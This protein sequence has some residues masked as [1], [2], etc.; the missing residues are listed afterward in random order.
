MPTPASTLSLTAT[1]RDQHS[2]HLPDGSLNPTGYHIDFE[3]ALGAETG[4]VE[5]MLGGD[6]K[7]VYALDGKPSTTT[8]GKA[9]FDQWY[10]DV[11]NVN[12]SQQI[13]FTLNLTAGS[14]PPQYT[15]SN[16]NFFPIDGML[17]GNE[18]FSHNFS[19]TVELHTKFRYNGGEQFSFTGDDDVFVF[20]NG[21]LAIDLGGV[22]GAESGM[23]DLDS[24][25]STLGITTCNVYSFDLFY[26][27][28]HTTQSDLA[29]T[30][31]LALTD[32]PLG[33]QREIKEHRRPPG[34]VDDHPIGSPAVPIATAIE[35]LGVL[36][37]RTTTSARAIDRDIAT[38]PVPIGVTNLLGRASRCEVIRIR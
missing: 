13:M 11:P 9:A 6:M 12:M 10:N 38:T 36:T 35:G 29:M 18:G 17:L 7:P 3:N 31:T 5:T 16:D 1:I 27:E 14:M 37:R 24:M 26:N 21:V 33:D 20:L 25:A 15:F 32:K 22:H 28:R 30:T 2:Y 8:H 4:I 23:V 34:L 19:F